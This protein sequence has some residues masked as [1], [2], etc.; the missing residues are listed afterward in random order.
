MFFRHQVSKNSVVLTDN[1]LHDGSISAGYTET[2]FVR[3]RSRLPFIK[4]VG[5]FFFKSEH[6]HRSEKNCSEHAQSQTN[7]AYEELRSLWQA[8]SS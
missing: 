8:V 2:S 1:Q 4:L 5:F 3:E 7:M 6:A